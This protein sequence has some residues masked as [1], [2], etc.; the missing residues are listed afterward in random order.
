[1]KH[2]CL[3]LLWLLLPLCAAGCQNAE[4][5]RIS[6]SQWWHAKRGGSQKPDPA[7]APHAASP[8]EHGSTSPDDAPT[9]PAAA[10]RPIPSANAVYSDVLIVNDKT[11]TVADILE[12]LLPMIEKMARELPP[13]SYYR[14]AEDL[15]RQQIIEIVAQHLIW[16]R[17]E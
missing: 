8:T 13:A 5:Q 11:I 15:V 12:P 6:M 4:G 2:V 10:D 3:I 7:T 14:R 9:P 1:M 16:R 17:A